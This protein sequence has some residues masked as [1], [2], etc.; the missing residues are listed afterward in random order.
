MRKKLPPDQMAKIGRVGGLATLK[1]KGSKFF[2][3]ISM[4]RKKFAGGRPRKD[5]AKGK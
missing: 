5:A 2:S 4:R 1:N 3:K